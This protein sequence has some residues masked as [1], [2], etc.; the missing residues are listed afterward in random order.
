MIGPD[1]GGA[2]VF[3][4]IF[5]TWVGGCEVETV[6]GKL[7][8]AEGTVVGSITGDGPRTGGESIDVVEDGWEES[9]VGFDSLEI[10]TSEETCAEL[11]EGTTGTAGTGPSGIDVGGGA[12]RGS[13]GGF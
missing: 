2:C 9:V 4:G 5:G 7:E 3:G 8:G 10:G 13:A 1:I 6:G 12:C 11:D